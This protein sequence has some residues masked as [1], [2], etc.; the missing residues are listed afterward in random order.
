MEFENTQLAPTTRV[1]ASEPGVDGTG[2]W[3]RGSAVGR[4]VLLD[5]IGAGGMGTVYAAYDPD[6]DRKV[7]L[8]LVSPAKVGAPDSTGRAWLLREAQAL[9]RL[10]HPN[11][12]AVHDVGTHG[13][14]VWIAME[15]VAGRTLGAWAEAKPRR[16]DECLHVLTDVAR[17][18][19]AAHEQGLVHR[20]LKPDNVMIGDDGRVRV[21]D[22][23]LAHGRAR[24]QGEDPPAVPPSSDARARP[25]LA[26]LE[27]R[28]TQ[29]GAI[30]GT[31]SYMAPEQ[32]QGKEA[33]AAADQFGWSVMAWEL[34]YGERPFA[35]ETMAA[36][37]AAV[38]G[39]I[40]RPP[41]R[42]RHVP[43]W[44]RKVVE[45]GLAVDPRQRW[46]TMAALLAALESGRKRARRR[47]A[48]IA[49]GAALML[50]GGGLGYQRWDEASRVAACTASGAAIE[51]VWNAGTREQLR[52]AFA[53]TGLPYATS[54]FERVGSWLDRHTEA[55]RS[56][57]T[58]VCLNARVRGTWD[59]EAWRRA[60]WC[61][62]ERR[63]AI[64][65]LV[66][67]FRRPDADVVQHA[68][69][70]AA[71]LSGVEACADL[72]LLRRL[73][74]PPPRDQREI[75]EALADLAR[76]RSLQLARR[77]REGL[78]VARRARVRARHLE[79]A[80]LVAAALLRE[81]SILRVLDEYERA[82]EVTERAY[83]EAV[84][85]SAWDVAADAAT[86]LIAILDRL[87]R[88]PEGET[89]AK[90][91][92]AA[93]S[94]AGDPTGLREARRLRNL[95]SIRYDAGAWQ[96]MRALW[97]R[98]LALT[99]QALG[100]THPEVADILS[101]M[102]YVLDLETY[103]ERRALSERA[104]AVAEATLGPDHPDLVP[105]LMS[106]SAI[107]RAM[108]AAGEARALHERAFKIVETTLPPDDLRLA[109]AMHDLGMAAYSD[110]D[111]ATAE[112]LGT[113]AYEMARA[114]LGDDA[115][116][117][118]D[119]SFVLRQ[120]KQAR[121]EYDDALE[122][123]RHALRVYE[124]H[125]GKGHYVIA[126]AMLS[127]AYLQMSMG[128]MHEAKRHFEAALRLRTG[129][130]GD[131]PGI[132]YAIVGLA[133]VERELGAF[134]ASLRLC[135]RAL[136]ATGQG[137]EADPSE[138]VQSL[139]CLAQSSMA[140]GD[141]PSSLDYAQRA[142]ALDER[143]L[144]PEGRR[145]AE[146][147]RM[148]A[149]AYL[150][151]G[152]HEEA[153]SHCERALALEE[154]AYG[155]NAIATAN[156][157]WCLANVHAALG[158]LAEE[159]T[160]R[161]RVVEITERAFGPDTGGL[162]WRRERLGL[163][164]ETMGDL[165]AARAEYEQAAATWEKLLGPENIHRAASL[166]GL[167]RLDLAEGKRR[168]ALVALERLVMRFDALEGPQSGEADARF[169]LARA[170]GPERGARKRAIAEAIKARDMYRRGGAVTA[171]KLAEVEAWLS[172]QGWTGEE[173]KSKT[174]R[175]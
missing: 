143:T 89:W 78:E 166:A 93:S 123:S 168:E 102:M 71:N 141:H 84:D 145:V 80:P 10:S 165:Q 75:R 133:N 146:D 43:G 149:Q 125:L 82:R 13:D 58:E 83:F 144:G 31:P 99:E 77:Y 64:A 42:D 79:W 140:M 110:Y 24:A 3:S 119:L 73:P 106:L 67:E 124:K 129:E 157:L 7:A 21:M 30:L 170:L 74:E 156:S 87:E 150:R 52:E 4:Y 86:E 60:T 167:A 139:T 61:L 174:S 158:E 28:L 34:L 50:A 38:T 59:A 45:R 173:L 111:Y 39:G 2:Q 97:E 8:K 69:S 100:S 33:D 117:T 95:A 23:G 18:V 91:A 130:G 135:E 9:A 112:A 63:M 65:S 127:I 6:L 137:R 27:M 131:A 103:A 109:F 104:L 159:L 68:A 47:M 40:R 88:D 134:E 57:Q 151:L 5:R 70:A 126:N 171:A 138:T 148:V 46:P 147:L 105:H 16:W 153:R 152:R 172:Q 96:E 14:R 169:A 163:V 121:G 32:W 113:R 155:D 98:T 53:A 136:A 22:F 19:A 108:G 101:E 116:T 94:I 107:R 81:G 154:R 35:G 51:A 132:T 161:R 12:V 1:G 26:A 48:G 160:L 54:T 29:A 55:W 15:F 66:A 164:Y 118:V 90:H 49:V 44:L 20:D 175:R 62:D 122:M 76:A 72:D 92:G 11:V 25:E 17:G 36:L 142:L 56:A 37:A 120:V 162:A 128:E 85:G 41:P 114:A 115:P